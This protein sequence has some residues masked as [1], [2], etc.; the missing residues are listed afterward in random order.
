MRSERMTCQMRHTLGVSR[1]GEI[2]LKTLFAAPS[3]ARFFILPSVLLFGCVEAT[4][5]QTER[6][7]Y[8]FAGNPDGDGPYA[9]L[10][11]HNGIFY[12]TTRSGGTFGH[13][14]VFEITTKGK[15][16]VLH[17]FSGGADGALP[18][19]SLVFDK[20]GNLYGT[21]AGGGILDNGTVFEI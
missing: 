18:L 8:S 16:K 20:L 11:R 21:T 6:L 7:L 9:S 12:G 14:T 10:V 4:Q 2:L 17:S 15:E 1:L 19:G 13:G 5:A 3:S